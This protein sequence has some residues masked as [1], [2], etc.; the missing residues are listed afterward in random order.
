MQSPFAFL[1]NRQVFLL[2]VRVCRMSQLPCAVG[3]EPVWIH[4]PCCQAHAD[5]WRSQP[6]GTSENRF[7]TYT[8]PVSKK[9]L[10]L[11]ST[12]IHPSQ[13]ETVLKK[14]VIHFGN[15]VSRMLFP[16]WSPW[17]TE[18]S[19]IDGMATR[20]G[21]NVLSI[22]RDLFLV[23]ISGDYKSW[24]QHLV[25]CLINNRALVIST[26]DEGKVPFS[27]AKWEIIFSDRISCMF[28]LLT[29]G[30]KLWFFCRASIGNRLLLNHLR[31]LL[32]K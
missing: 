28:I 13:S 4:K 15:L 5:S 24:W 1:H 27:V 6:M 18:I 2:N 23:M 9:D 8:L 22:E 25:Q 16:H 7:L 32:G 21:A 31:V 30:N 14:R 3:P 26:M 12:G 20:Q 29:F 17:W 10:G 19:K 11:L